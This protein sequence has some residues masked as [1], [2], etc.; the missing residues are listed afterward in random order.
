[1]LPSKHMYIS[2]NKIINYTVQPT[3]L[4]KWDRDKKLR[5]KDTHV[6][7]FRKIATERPFP[8]TSVSF[9][10]SQGY[11]RHFTPF[12]PLTTPTLFQ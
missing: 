4:Q 9:P 12:P 7:Y 11:N 1:M 10:V 8:L 2:N 5:K 6:S 3:K